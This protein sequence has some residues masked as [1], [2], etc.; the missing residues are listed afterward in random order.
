[1]FIGRS[2][3]YGSLDEAGGL[4]W[5]FG[6]LGWGGRSC[7]GRGFLAASVSGGWPLGVLEAVGVGHVVIGCRSLNGALA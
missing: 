2:F 3:K 6:G 7:G 4:G 5:L 1:M